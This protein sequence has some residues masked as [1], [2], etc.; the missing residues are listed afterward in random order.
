MRSTTRSPSS[1]SATTGICQGN[2]PLL[3]LQRLDEGRFAI[4]GQDEGVFEQ[5]PD[6]TFRSMKGTH[7]TDLSDAGQLKLEVGKDR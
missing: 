5:L 2:Q 6:G 1:R 3:F 4:T 7:T